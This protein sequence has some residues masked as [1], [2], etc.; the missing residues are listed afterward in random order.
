MDFIK[1]VNKNRGI[2]FADLEEFEDGGDKKIHVLNKYDPKYTAY[3]DSLDLFN[4]SI[5]NELN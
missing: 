4:Q 5:Q 2:R 1:G 3:R